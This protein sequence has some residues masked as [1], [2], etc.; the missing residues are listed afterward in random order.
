MKH[1]E[2]EY[3]THDKVKLYLQA[4]LPEQPKASMLLVH[5]LAEHSGRY[6]HF[7]EKM[8]GAGI[9]VFT[10]D[11]RG[12]GKSAKASPSAYFANHL[13]Y[14]QDIDVLFKKMQTYCP[15]VPAFIFGHSMG[16]GMVAS[17]ALQYQPKAK[18][19]VLSAPALE[20][21]E[22]ISKFLIGVSGLLSKIA[23]KLKVLKLDS[24]KISHD[25]KEVEKY[26]ADPLVYHDPIP[27]RTGYELLR[28]MQG[29]KAQ[30]AAFNYPVLLLHG[31]DDLLTD[32]KGTASFFR[33]I[34]SEDK[35]FHRY[36]G[37]YHELINEFEK[38]TVIGDVLEWV[39][40]RCG[41]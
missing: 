18:G 20:P 30:A 11:G 13:D 4:W 24:R 16:G 3:I 26:D 21:S 9:A 2:T 1:F 37:L 14:V 28:L 5:G 15:E 6:A 34:S 7:A 27:A 36:P 17:F 31:S 25:P 22:D 33:N 12:H 32:P 41:E 39:M 10:F 38:E 29:I 40:E 19:I 8:V 23:P 35:T